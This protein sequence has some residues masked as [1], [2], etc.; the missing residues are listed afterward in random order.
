MA[1]SPR[2]GS[3]VNS[4]P[5]SCSGRYHPHEAQADSILRHAADADIPGFRRLAR[6]IDRWSD[7][8]L[9]CQTTGGASNGRTEAVNLL[10]EKIRRVDH[11]YRNFDNYRR[12]PLLGC[13]ITWTTV[14]VRRIRG[15][16]P[17]FSASSR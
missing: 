14:P 1:K 15:R 2:S 16:K 8:I 13:G 17:A 12:R 7:E 9:A 4:L 11:G 6:T 10:V 3:P 5:R